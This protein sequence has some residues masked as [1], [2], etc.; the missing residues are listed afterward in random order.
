[1]SDLPQFT[2]KVQPFGDH[3]AVVPEEMETMTASG[4]VIPDTAKGEKSAI[5]TVIA[6]GN[7]EG[8]KDEKNPTK[9]FKVGEKVVFG[10]YSGEDIELTTKDGSKKEVKFLSIDSIRAKI[11]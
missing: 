3:I 8:Q 5:G 11:A 9:Y 10:K 7:G 6:V 2:V 4:I 1:M